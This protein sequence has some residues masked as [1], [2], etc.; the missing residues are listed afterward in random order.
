MKYLGLTLGLLVLLG[1]AAQAV[2]QVGDH[3]D[4]FTLTD[5]FGNQVSLYDYA[6]QVI[7]I[8]FWT[9]G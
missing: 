1:G 4:D 7:F 2:Y 6:N 8:D 3:V 5:A 9:P